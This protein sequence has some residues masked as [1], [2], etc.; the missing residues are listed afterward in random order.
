VEDRL[1]ETP[2]EK[3]F[4]FDDKVAAVFDDMIERSVPFYRHNQA[5]IAEIVCCRLHPGSRLVDLGCSTGGLLLEVA[6]RCDDGVV[7]AGVDNA[8]AMIERARKKA[9]AY[10]VSILFHC[11]DLTTWPIGEA[12]I[13]IANY[14]LQFIRPLQRTKV[15]RRIYEALKPD[16]LFIFSEK[17]L[18]RNKWLDKAIIDI[19]HD[20]KKR[21]GYSETE[22][23]QKR[24]ALEN[25]L[26][27]YTIAENI[28]MLQEAGFSTID[29]VFQW[30]NFAT[31]VAS[32]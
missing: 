16:G 6:R 12:D 25:V 3:K 31:F 22:I 23:A 20:F 8:A 28:A 30:G 18:M 19:Y 15:V 11:D 4:E 1:F 24:A 13:V 26:V 14:T 10:G 7:L 17:V 2:I 29:T 9:E 5:L 27:P 21:Q 32:K